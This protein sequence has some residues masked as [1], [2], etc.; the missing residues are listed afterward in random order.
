MEFGNSIGIAFKFIR[1]TM[2]MIR[3]QGMEFMSGKMDGFIKET[4]IRT[5]E[6][7]M[8]N[9]MMAIRL[10]IED[11]GKTDSKLLENPIMMTEIQTRQ[12]LM[13]IFQEKEVTMVGIVG[14][15]TRG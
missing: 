8:G 2:R 13:T 14:T 11:I 10:F 3:N 5:I 12:A 6:M 7:D 4:S 9:F 15:E 1:V